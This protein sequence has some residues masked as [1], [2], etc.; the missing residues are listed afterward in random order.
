MN[1]SRTALNAR[2]SLLNFER[3]ESTI[4]T[5]RDKV[6]SNIKEALLEQYQSFY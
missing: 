1:T 2:K 4:D 3:V 6:K 5:A